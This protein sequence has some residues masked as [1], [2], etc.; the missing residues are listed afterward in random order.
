MERGKNLLFMDKKKKEVKTGKCSP[1]ALQIL[2][3]R[4]L[5]V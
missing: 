1:T 4:E 3:G 5:A 2:C